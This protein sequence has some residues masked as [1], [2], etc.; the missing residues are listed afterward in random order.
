MPYPLLEFEAIDG[1]PVAFGQRWENITRPGET[2]PSYK[3]LGKTTSRGVS[4]CIDFYADEATAAAAMAAI[5][6]L[7]GTSVNLKRRQT[8]D[9]WNVK[10]MGVRCRTREVVASNGYRWMLSA[11]LETERL[12]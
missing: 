4:R 10:L 11:E 9:A 1:D 3:Y 2:E 6:A 7:Q 8:G 12:P 5:E